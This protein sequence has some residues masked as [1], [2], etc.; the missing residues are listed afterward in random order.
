[1]QLCIQK[2]SARV[3]IMHLIPL[4]DAGNS[5]LKATQTLLAI[6]NIALKK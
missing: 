3:T 5:Q 1:M 4:K 2:T 6:G